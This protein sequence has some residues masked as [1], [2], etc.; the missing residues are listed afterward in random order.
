[1]TWIIQVDP[2]IKQY[3][4][5]AQ[6]TTKPTFSKPPVKE[7]EDPQRQEGRKNQVGENPDVGTGRLQAEVQQKKEEDQHDADNDDQPAKVTDRI[8]VKAASFFLVVHF[9]PFSTWP[10]RPLVVLGNLT[11]GRALLRSD[12]FEHLFTRDLFSFEEIRCYPIKP[13]A[14]LFQ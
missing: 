14:V 11:A 6:A 8:T 9:H 5:D 4:P 3:L 13:V 10:F 1:M 12:E 2:G 7:E